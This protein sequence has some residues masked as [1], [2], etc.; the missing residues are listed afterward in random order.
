[1]NT[2]LATPEKPNFISPNIERGEYYVLDLDADNK[3]NL[4]VACG[5]LE[6]CS[7]E[8][9]L[10]RKRFRYYGIE[11]IVA[12]KCS[13]ILDGKESELSAGS[14]FSYT[15]NCHH[16]I[17][18][19]GDTPLVKYFIDFSANGRT[20]LLKSPIFQCLRAYKPESSNWVAH[21]FQDLQECGAS[22]TS[23][24]QNI[25]GHLLSYLVARLEVSEKSESQNTTPSFT[26]FESC[27][28]YIES[29]YSNISSAHEVADMFHISHQYLCRL[30]KRFCDETPSQMLIRLKLTRS[31]SLLEQGNLLVKEIAEKVGF[32]DQYYFSKRFKSYFGLSPRNYIKSSGHAMIA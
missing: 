30:F 19:T 17:I 25:C 16:K 28:S 2:P 31:A 14:V 20:N 8:Y 4:T 29:N 7:L 9:K 15:P 13:L 1:M 22:N 27:R 11:Y 32:E 26:T 12:G 24:A 21:V 10:E 23:H 18:N 5:G 3:Q 6:Q